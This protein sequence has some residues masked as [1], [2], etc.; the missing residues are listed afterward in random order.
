MNSVK[1]WFHSSNL[2]ALFA[3]FVAMG[4]TAVAL[5]KAPK[6]SVTSPSIRNGA[7][8]GKDVKDNSLTGADVDEK[9]LDV[10]G[11][12]GAPGPEGPQGPAGP[13]GAT[14]PAGPGATQGGIGR[15]GF[16]GQ[17]DPEGGT[18]GPCSATQVTLTAP[19]RVLITG[20]VEAA[21]EPESLTHALGR[22]VL[23]VN[24]DAILASLLDVRV[25]NAVPVTQRTLTAVSSVLPA[26]TH[27][28]SV[29]CAE[30]QNGISYPQARLSAVGL[31]EA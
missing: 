1:K 26:G 21:K 20:T 23:R 19:G 5:T 29:S 16:E 14:G 25:D 7:V 11:T 10:A 6:N 31:S 18:Y 9:S 4:G 27:S 30:I 15:Y 8:T 13:Q 28:V 3:V 2:I 22:C 17:C 24:S 12:R